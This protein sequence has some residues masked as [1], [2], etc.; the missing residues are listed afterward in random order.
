M[1]LCFVLYNKQKV[2]LKLFI[3]FPSLKLSEHCVLFSSTHMTSP[4]RVKHN[5]NSA[6]TVFACPSGANFAWYG[7][8]YIT[9]SQKQI[10]MTILAFY[11]YCF[12]NFAQITVTHI[13]R[14]K[15]RNR[16]TTW[17]HTSANHAIT[18]WFHIDW[19]IRNTIARHFNFR[20]LCKESKRMIRKIKINYPSEKK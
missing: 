19:G 1:K 15:Q 2:L 11:V 20:H 9:M 8:V 4:S 5:F 3:H 7:A 18:V 16:G 6:S 13:C 12:A 17:S 10:G 14:K